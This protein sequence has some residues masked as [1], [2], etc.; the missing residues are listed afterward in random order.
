V[1]LN[2]MWEKVRGCGPNSPMVGWL[3]KYL[4]ADSGKRCTLAYFH[5]E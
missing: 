3:E 5:P 4:A 1:V 2:S